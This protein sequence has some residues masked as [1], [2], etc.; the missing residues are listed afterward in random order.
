[1]DLAGTETDPGSTAVGS[2][3]HCD[4][5]HTTRGLEFKETQGVSPLPTL[6]PLHRH[7]K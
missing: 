5:L 6:T 2:G 3:V 7:S 1:M 4:R